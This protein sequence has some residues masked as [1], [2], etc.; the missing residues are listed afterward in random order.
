MKKILLLEDDETMNEGITMALEHDGFSVIGCFSIGEA[1]ERLKKEIIDL[2]V[3]DVNLP[4][5]SGFLF[6]REIRQ[7][8]RI[9]IIL[10]TARDLELDIVN[11]LEAGADDYI[12]KPFSLMVFRARIHALLRR[13]ETKQEQETY[14]E[15]PFSFGFTEM[16]FFRDGRS[17]E[18]SKTEQKLLYYLIANRGRTLTREQILE[19]VWDDADSVEDNALS[20]TVKRLREKLEENPAKPEY[21]RTVYGLG[22]VW[23]REE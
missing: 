22:Y 18:L 1:R 21:L 11:G 13:T 9:P 7:K 14:E 4:D 20:V 10:L 15:G 8:S 16:K 17:V 6:C 23:G 2:C 5:G 3:L 19:R 12:V